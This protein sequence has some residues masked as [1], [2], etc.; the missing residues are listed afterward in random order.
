MKNYLVLSIITLFLTSCASEK[1]LKD[2]RDGKTYKI[3][4]FGNQIW[5]TENLNYEMENS[6]CW[7]D[8]TTKCNEFG[9]LYTWKAALNSCPVGWHLPSHEEWKEFE[10]FVGI[11]EDQL[12]IKGFEGRG[13]NEGMKIREDSEFGFNVKLAG[14][15]WMSNGKNI[16]ANVGS[17]AYFWSATKTTDDKTL[18]GEHA[19]ARLIHYNWKEIGC[20]N[21]ETTKQLS[22]RCIK[23]K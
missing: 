11:P 21:I 19:K 3:K 20:T 4:R 9:R 15:C 23:D 6:N 2:E 8:D 14:I 16:G 13:T 18:T 22:V 1:I 10:K 12:D 5:M 7:Q 17:D